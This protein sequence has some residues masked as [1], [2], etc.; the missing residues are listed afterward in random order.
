MLKIIKLKQETFQWFLIFFKGLIFQYLLL[1]QEIKNADICVRH[2]YILN[3]M[4]INTCKGNIIFKNEWKDLNVLNNTENKR[5]TKK[6][7][8][9]S[10]SHF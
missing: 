1:K 7:T 8:L 10:K 5:R 3:R 6:D 4:H 2:L 9:E